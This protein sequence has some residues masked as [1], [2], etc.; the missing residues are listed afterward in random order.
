MGNSLAEGIRFSGIL[1]S[2]AT[3]ATTGQ[4]TVQPS[5]LRVGINR[6]GTE[7]VKRNFIT[8]LT[9]AIAVTWLV[10]S[11]YDNAGATPDSAQRAG[12]RMQVTARSANVRSGPG[13]ENGIVARASRGDLVV[14]LLSGEGWTKVRLANGE[15]GWIANSLLAKPDSRKRPTSTRG[16]PWY[17]GGTLHKANA[18]EWHGASHANKLATCADFITRKWKGK[19]LLPQMTW[20]IR[21]VDD[22]RPFAEELVTFIDD[23]VAPANGAPADRK[24]MADTKVADLASS[25]MFLLGWIH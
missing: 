7:G 24:L 5:P 17:R 21:S 16:A 3:V 8:I 11:V 1:A 4:L 25:G 12:E 15:V 2:R 9:A 23:A 22:I 13:T 19:E 6:A 18:L 20:E 14:L 10:P